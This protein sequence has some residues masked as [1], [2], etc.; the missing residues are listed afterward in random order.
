[1]MQFM[2][3]LF[4]GAELNV[5]NLCVHHINYDKDDLFEF[6]LV[7]LCRSCNGKVNSRRDMWRDYF[8]F[9]IMCGDML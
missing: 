8:T 9:R 4:F 5:K 2:R 1:M 7:T 6:N 3:T